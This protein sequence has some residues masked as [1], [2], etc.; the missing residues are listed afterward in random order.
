MRFWSFNSS[1][2]ARN[3]LF[4]RVIIA[5]ASSIFPKQ[6]R[7]RSQVFA[8]HCKC[9]HCALLTDFFWD[10]R[11][12][13][14]FSYFSTSCFNV[15]F[16]FCSVLTSQPIS[17][18]SLRRSPM[19]ASDERR[20]FVDR[21]FV[22]LFWDDNSR[23]ASLRRLRVRNNSR[24]RLIESTREQHGVNGRY[25][26]ESYVHPRNRCDESACWTS[27]NSNV[28]LTLVFGWSWPTLL[29]RSLHWSVE[30]YVLPWISM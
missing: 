27:M 15:S 3:S 20:L 24:R 30:W 22:R 26:V 6:R 21:C 2:V 16:V 23:W 19:N 7:E 25:S 1:M 12:T 11:V 28:V 4:S 17:L 14:S 8:L 13:T 9:H 10:S 29:V 18:I 5:L